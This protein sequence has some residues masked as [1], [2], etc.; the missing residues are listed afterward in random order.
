MGGR[1]ANHSIK[2]LSAESRAFGSGGP[3]LLRLFEP[4]QRIG[5]AV[6]RAAEAGCGAIGRELALCRQHQVQ[7][8]RRGA[9][10]PERDP[11]VV[12]GEPAC[13]EERAEEK[14]R[15]EPLGASTRFPDTDP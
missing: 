9:D 3:Q 1:S 15:S 5:E 2:G 7:K 10:H 14:E 11:I 8:R 13:G 4:D 12:Q 6:R